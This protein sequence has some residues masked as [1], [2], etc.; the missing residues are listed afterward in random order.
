MRA[1][2][3]LLLAWAALPRLTGSPER[4]ALAVSTLLVLLSTVHP[5]RCGS[6]P[7]ALRGYRF[8]VHGA[9]LGLLSL[10]MSASPRLAVAFMLVSVAL[11]ERAFRKSENP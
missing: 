9:N 11:T 8:A 2:C 1:C 7:A 10:G 5:L 3:A 6:G 4:I